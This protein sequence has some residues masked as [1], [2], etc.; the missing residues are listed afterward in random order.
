MISSASTSSRKAT[1]ETSLSAVAPSA[2]IDDLE[3][4]GV[5]RRRLVVEH[6]QVGGCRGCGDEGAG[7]RRLARGLDREEALFAGKR[8][9]ARG[10][11]V[12]ASNFAEITYRS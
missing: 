11:L 10:S 1:R 4:R 5:G 6:H 3:D 12:L 9:A 8:E 7:Q 2:G